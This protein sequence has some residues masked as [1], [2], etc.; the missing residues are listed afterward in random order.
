MKIHLS[1]SKRNAPQGVST[2]VD[3][4]ESC[5]DEYNHKVI[6]EPKPYI[7]SNHNDPKKSNKA[8]TKQS[9]VAKKW[10]YIL[11][12]SIRALLLYFNNRKLINKAD[13]LICHDVFVLIIANL[14]S[15][16]PLTLYNHSDGNPIDTLSIGAS[17]TLD[18]FAIRIVASLFFRTNLNGVYSLSDTANE[19]LKVDF[20]NRKN[21]QFLTIDNFTK[22]QKPEKEITKEP[23]VWLVGTVC[24]RKRQVEY[25]EKL[26]KSHLNVNYKFNLLGSCSSI[27]REALLSTGLVKSVLCVDDI[28]EYISRGDIL[29]SLSENEGLP[30]AMLESSSIGAVL[31][32]TDVGG[33]SKICRNLDNGILLGSKPTIEEVN[34]AISNIINNDVSRELY[35]KNSISIHNTYFSPEANIKQWL[36]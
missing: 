14:F 27:D 17:T 34:T 24:S 8:L 19:K 30:M 32:S 7:A 3:N 29:L 1:I 28:K 4:I 15:H 2:V 12:F 36:I 16:V 13:G 25:I 20:N 35:A 21:I 26:S 5:F 9:L 18:K 33:C 10:I 6:R 11:Y 23:K 31:V 22:K